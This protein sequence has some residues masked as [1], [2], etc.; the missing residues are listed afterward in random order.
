MSRFGDSVGSKVNDLNRKDFNAQV[1]GLYTG[2]VLT[3]NDPQQ[4]GRCRVQIHGIDEEGLDIQNYRWTPILT[5]LAGV[6]VNV[7]I[8][9]EKED[10]TGI[11]SYGKF[12]IPKVGS[13]VLIMFIGGRLSNPVII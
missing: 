1:N 9:P 4:M 12:E 6:Q 10:A 2:V 11:T 13:V 7:P 5:S 3:N 8:G